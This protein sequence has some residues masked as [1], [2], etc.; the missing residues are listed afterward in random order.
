MRMSFDHRTKRKN[1]ETFLP[2]R[3]FF[4]STSVTNAV[5]VNYTMSSR[6]KN[7]RRNWK[8]FM[9]SIE[10]PWSNIRLVK[11]E[12]NPTCNETSIIKNEKKRSN[13]ER[14][15]FLPKDKTSLITTPWLCPTRLID[16]HNKNNKQKRNCQWSSSIHLIISSFISFLL[17]SFEN[18]STNRI[19]FFCRSFLQRKNSYLVEIAA[20]YFN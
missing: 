8:V 2:F 4:L 3:F 14:A 18:K 11:S 15:A 10:K 5:N 16:N 17:L 9:K 20:I 19:L 7:S 6:K 12:V 1:A 13:T